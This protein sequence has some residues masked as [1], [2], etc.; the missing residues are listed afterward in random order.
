M[1]V[2]QHENNGMARSSK[3]PVVQ[4]VFRYLQSPN[5]ASTF[6]T[7][8]LKLRSDIPEVMVEFSKASMVRKQ[9]KESDGN[10]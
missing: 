1:Y 2:S 6:H 10:A 9:L 4:H 8:T 5:F 7:V 3:I